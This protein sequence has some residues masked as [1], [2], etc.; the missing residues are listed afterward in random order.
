MN[1]IVPPKP[2]IDNIEN[3]KNKSQGGLKLIFLGIVV[4]LC[5]GI[6]L[7]FPILA[8]LDIVQKIG[9]GAD[10]LI[11]YEKILGYVLCFVGVL[12]IGF[13]IYK[14][15]DIKQPPNSVIH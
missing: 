14:I 1:Q 7:F 10:E 3:F 2:Q 15:P 8:S 9:G 6:L 11:H 5:G 4:G 12:L 13:G